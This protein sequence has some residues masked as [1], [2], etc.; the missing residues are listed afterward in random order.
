[1]KKYILIQKFYP[2]LEMELN[3]RKYCENS[4]VIF[5]FFINIALH[6]QFFTSIFAELSCLVVDDT[7]KIDLC[8]ISAQTMTSERKKQDFLF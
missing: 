3:C 2:R 6:I 4:L 7:I 8:K 1:M 5:K